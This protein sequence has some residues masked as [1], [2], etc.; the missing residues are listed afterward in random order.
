MKWTAISVSKHLLPVR[1]YRVIDHRG[2]IV[3]LLAQCFVDEF[4]YSGRGWFWETNAEGTLSY[5]SQTLVCWDGVA[6]AAPATNSSP[7]P[8]TASTRHAD[9]ANYAFADGHVKWL[10]PQAF[11]D[12]AFSNG[13]PQNGAAGTAY[14]N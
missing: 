6:T 10:K 14:L 7:P 13:A 5:V 9:G 11:N 8:T 3:I 12:S 4:E 1:R 2:N